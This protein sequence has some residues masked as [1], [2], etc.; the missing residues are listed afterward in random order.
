MSN[1]DHFV[2][3]QTTEAGASWLSV[4]PHQWVR[5]NVLLWP[6]NKANSFYEDA[7]SN[8][9]IH[10]LQSQQPTAEQYL[11]AFNSGKEHVTFS[12]N[13][14][15]QPFAMHHRQPLRNVPQVFDNDTASQSL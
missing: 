1:G 7:S 9:R 11:N 3:L 5:G 8:P 15:S 2:V 4:L 6:T 10:F 12:P 14:I 13:V